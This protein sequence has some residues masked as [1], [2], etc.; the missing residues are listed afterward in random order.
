[1]GQSQNSKSSAL[2]HWESSAGPNE[3]QWLYLGALEFA[4]LQDSEKS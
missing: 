2:S 4:L 3:S 1:M